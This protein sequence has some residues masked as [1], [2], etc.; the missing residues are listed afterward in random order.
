MHTNYSEC[1]DM[2]FGIW[3]LIDGSICVD[4]TDELLEISYL[5]I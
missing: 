5:D 3:K 1:E 2:V 4:R